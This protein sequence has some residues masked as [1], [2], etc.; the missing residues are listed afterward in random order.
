MKKI[1]NFIKEA[2][3]ELVKVNWPTKKQT[4][5]YTLIVLGISF[6]VAVF[7]GGL[8][9]LFGEILKNFIV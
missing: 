9:W 1:V 5:N 3:E 7:L 8:D 4:V 6:F 2:R